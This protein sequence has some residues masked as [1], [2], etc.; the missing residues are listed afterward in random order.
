MFKTTFYL[1]SIK[2]KDLWEKKSSTWTFCSSSPLRDYWNIPFLLEQ[3]NSNNNLQEA[4]TCIEY[5][6]IQTA[7]KFARFLNMI[8]ID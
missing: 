6:F 5:T 1:N 2:F 3:G 8:N 4:T 7:K